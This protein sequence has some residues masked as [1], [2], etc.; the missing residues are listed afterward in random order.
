MGRGI[1]GR[2]NGLGIV[3]RFSRE[4]DTR[5]NVHRS[6]LPCSIFNM[7]IMLVANV[8]LNS[9]SEIYKFPVRLFSWRTILCSKYCIYLPHFYL[10]D[11][12]P[13]LVKN[14]DRTVRVS[15]RFN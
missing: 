6:P 8:S 4:G 5:K 1:G 3:C 2:W 11:M 7:I 10:Y 13:K 14:Y 12:M 15:Q 9:S